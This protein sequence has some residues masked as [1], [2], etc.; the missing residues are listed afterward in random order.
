M[1]RF[2]I[3]I[4]FIIGIIHASNFKHI[5]CKEYLIKY[6]YVCKINLKKEY[7][8]DFLIKI[9][10]FLLGRKFFEYKF[11]N[12]FYKICGRKGFFDNFKKEIGIKDSKYLFC[13]SEHKEEFLFKNFYITEIPEQFLPNKI[14][15]YNYVYVEKNLLLFCNPCIP[16]QI[17]KLQLKDVPF[18]KIN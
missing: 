2:L 17:F 12:S 10:D 18:I 4:I 15:P 8:E 7:S 5:N 3:L 13:I 1:E 11:L 6:S 14:Y 16:K 9:V